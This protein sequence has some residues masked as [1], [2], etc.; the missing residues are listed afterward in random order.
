[1][2]A[3]FTAVMR[4]FAAFE[5]D[6]VAR[7]NAALAAAGKPALATSGAKRADVVGTE[8]GETDE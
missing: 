2:D 3:A 7:A 5:R 4:D 1:V 8:S 6:D